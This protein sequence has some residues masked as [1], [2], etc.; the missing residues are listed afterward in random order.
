MDLSR[1][2]RLYGL[3]ELFHAASGS[4]DMAVY[5]IGKCEISRV[6]KCQRAKCEI[7]L[8]NISHF[9]HRYSEHIFTLLKI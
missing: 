4:A 1:S 8:Q 2:F 9:T 5:K 6:W 7:L 3:P